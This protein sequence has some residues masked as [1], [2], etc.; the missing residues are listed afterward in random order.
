MPAWT[1]ARRCRR[2]CGGRCRRSR[3]RR[4]DGGRRPSRSGQRLERRLQVAYEVGVGVV[5]DRGAQEGLLLPRALRSLGQL[6]ENGAL[7]VG[8]PRRNSFVPQDGAAQHDLSDGVEPGHVD[9]RHAGALGEDGHHR[10]AWD[11]FRGSG[12][13]GLRGVNDRLV[14]GDDG[15]DAARHHL[16]RP[17]PAVRTR[18]PPDVKVVPFLPRHGELLGRAED[19]NFLSDRDGLTGR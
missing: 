4:R 11:A 19:G 14:L 5:L 13:V 18:V 9:E 12:T 1:P 15:Q 8:G 16:V 3:S 17:H 7:N 10:H 2:R 6:Q